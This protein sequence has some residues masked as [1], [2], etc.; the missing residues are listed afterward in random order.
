MYHTITEAINNA[1]NDK[2]TRIIT[3]TGT[4][5]YFSSGND[6]SAFTKIDPSDMSAVKKEMDMAKRTLVD[7]VDCFI[8]YVYVCVH[9]ILI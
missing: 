6:L 3:L 2:S 7:F 9:E 1:S 8:E 5:K 4:G